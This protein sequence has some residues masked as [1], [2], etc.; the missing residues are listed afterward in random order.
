MTNKEHEDIHFNKDVYLF[1]ELIIRN[2]LHFPHELSK[3]A[4][5]LKQRMENKHNIKGDK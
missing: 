3:Q 4:I 2:K 5:D 1:L